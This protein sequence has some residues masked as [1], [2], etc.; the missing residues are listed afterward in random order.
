MFGLFGLISFFYLYRAVRLGY[1]IW[2][3]RAAFVGEPLRR[4]DK[5]WASE[6]AFL[7]AVPPSV[8]VHELFHALVVWGLGGKIVDFGFYFY[9]GYVVP[10][11]AFPA[12]QSWWISTAGTIGSLLFGILLYLFLR[13]HRS[14]T[15]RYFARQAL[16]CKSTLLSLVIQC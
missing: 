3:D 10:D 8:L 4:Q 5:S 9:A 11:R 14:T 13:N 12:V 7:I 15:M 2:Q 6:A 16:G 1:A